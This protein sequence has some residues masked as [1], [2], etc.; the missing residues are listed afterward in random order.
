MNRVIYRS[1]QDDF[2]IICLGFY[3]S[4][5]FAYLLFYAV[6]YKPLFN[7]TFLNEIKNAFFSKLT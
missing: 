1:F 6:F 7:L 2:V 5:N 4:T 3:K